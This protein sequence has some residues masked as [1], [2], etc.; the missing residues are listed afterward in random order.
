MSSEEKLKPV[1][2]AL[3]EIEADT[4]MP[5]QVKTKITATIA[6]LEGAGEVSMKVSRAL[7]DLEQLADD[8][9]TPSSA[10]TQL[11]NITSMLEVI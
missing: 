3:K 1:I 6:L 2:D 9:N 10:R 11:F 5:K 8:T 4:T 7:N